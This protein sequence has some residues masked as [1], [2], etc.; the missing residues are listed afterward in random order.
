MKYLPQVKTDIAPSP[1][2]IL[3]M[4]EGYFDPCPPNPKF[5]GLK[6]DWEK[7]NYVNPPYSNKK[8]W[9][10]KVILE[11]RKGNLSIMLL[12]QIPDAVW[13]QELVVPNSVILSFRGRL[14][15]DSGKHPMYSSMLAVFNPSID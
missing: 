6:I 13:Y 14:Q 15:L 4:F 3:K 8:P 10:E 1:K 7:R 12:P 9:I 2:W 11:Q 5:D